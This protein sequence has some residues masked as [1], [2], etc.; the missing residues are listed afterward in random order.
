M[1]QKQLFGNFFQIRL[2]FNRGRK[3]SIESC[4]KPIK[5]FNNKLL[6]FL[7]LNLFYENEVHFQ[8]FKYH[9]YNFA[10]RF[11]AHFCAKFKL[12]GISFVLYKLLFLSKFYLFS[13]CFDFWGQKLAIS[14]YF[15]IL[16]FLDLEFQKKPFFV[17]FV[18]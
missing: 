14:S 11:L 15:S 16:S 7:C 3:W 17:M 5:I 9:N 18:S 12:N 6:F 4:A 1:W 10:R 2:S 8:L 13:L